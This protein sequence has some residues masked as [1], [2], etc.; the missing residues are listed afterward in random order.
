MIDV[1][2]ENSKKRVMALSGRLLTMMTVDDLQLIHA[3]HE[4]GMQAGI[5]VNLFDDGDLSP[6]RGVEEALRKAAHEGEEIPMWYKQTVAVVTP[7][8]PGASS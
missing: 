6:F 4:Q 7:A 8:S 3:F 1:N 2:D 5:K